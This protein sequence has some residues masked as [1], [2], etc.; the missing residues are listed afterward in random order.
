MT[1]A[2]TVESVAKS[3]QIQRKPLTLVESMILYLAGRHG[4]DQT[5]WALSDISFSL[6]QGKVLGIIG[7]NG[8]GKSTLL[9]LLCGLGR[10][11]RGRI[12][13]RG[14]VSGLLELGSGLHLEMTG[15]ENIITAGILNGLTRKQIMAEQKEIIAF[16]ELEK[17]ID[18][19][20]RTYSSGMY[21]R[22]AFSAAIHFDPDVLM[23]DEVLAVGDSRF[24]QKC[25][26]R[27]HT[28]RKAGKTLVLVSH[29]T[30]QIRSLCD[31]VLVLEEGRIATQ[32]DPK[33]A[34]E[35]YNDLMRQRS[36]RRAA[37]LLGGSQ[38][39]LAVERGTRMGTQEATISAV[40]I[41]DGQGRATDT[42]Q[43][44]NNLTIILEY[45]L[46]KPLSDMA[47][48]VGISNETNVKC[49]ETVVP[50]IR[51]SLTP[52]GEKGSLDCYLPQ[53]PLLAGRYYIDVGLYPIDWNYVYDYHW[54]M[55]VLHV[56]NPNG[57]PP[58]VSGVISVRPV[59]SIQTRA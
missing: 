33:N 1:A 51:A 57:N 3:F 41:L 26:D 40:Q 48:I 2:L 42:L 18:Q 11:T 24:Q 34:I 27:L 52:P 44:G 30:D 56:E 22:L 15:R 4:K 8:A 12:D 29:N 16:A 54:H 10:P 17:F 43:T 50:S 36:E 32:G 55:H 6:D 37:Q 28:F 45:S 39:D 59:W 58:G 53:V 14:Y 20:V 7:H 46:A 25:L 13:R 9:R 23:I 49:F 21:L 35:C 19:P 47:V 5:L 38:P 31:E